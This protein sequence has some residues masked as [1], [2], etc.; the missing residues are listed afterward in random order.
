MLKTCIR[1]QCNSLKFKKSKAS[2]IWLLKNLKCETFDLSIENSKT[3]KKIYGTQYL[4][5]NFH[6]FGIYLNNIYP[7]VELQKFTYIHEIDNK[8]N[9]VFDFVF[10]EDCQFNVTNKSG[11]NIKFKIHQLNPASTDSYDVKLTEYYKFRDLQLD[12]LTSIEKTLNNA[13]IE[14]KKAVEEEAKKIVAQEARQRVIKNEFGKKK[15]EIKTIDKEKD[16]IKKAKLLE[17]LLDKIVDD[18]TEQIKLAEEKAINEIA[19]VALTKNKII[20]PHIIIDCPSL[21]PT[22]FPY[23]IYIFS[24]ITYLLRNGWTSENMSSQ[25]YIDFEKKQNKFQ[26]KISNFLSNR[27]FNL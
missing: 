2:S 3:G 10:V 23:E 18:T 6:E 11:F 7:G 19:T 9:T 13:C 12:N 4:N 17:Q 8:N 22:K 27:R 15:E 16:K 24:E 26:L 21:D 25:F 5:A 14:R 1:N 20:G